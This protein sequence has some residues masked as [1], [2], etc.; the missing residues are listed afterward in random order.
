VVFQIQME[1]FRNALN[2][3]N[4]NDLGFEGDVFTRRNTEMMVISESALIEL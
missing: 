1:H 3:C 2:F 4:L